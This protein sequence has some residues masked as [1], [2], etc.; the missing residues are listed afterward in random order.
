[1]ETGQGAG[2]KSVRREK[3]PFSGKRPV[4]PGNRF[5]GASRVEEPPGNDFRPG[6]PGRTQSDPPFATGGTV[7]LQLRDYVDAENSFRSCSECILVY[8]VK[9]S[10]GF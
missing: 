4:F 5:S 9:T 2:G 3:G 1:M 10:V 7:S 6:G 8:V